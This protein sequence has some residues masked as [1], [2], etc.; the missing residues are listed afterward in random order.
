MLL[1]LGEILLLNIRL[2]MMKISWSSE[3]I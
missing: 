2:R 3:T 1:V